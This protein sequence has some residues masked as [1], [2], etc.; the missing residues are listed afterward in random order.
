MLVIFL[1]EKLRLKLDTTETFNI[2]K[3]PSEMHGN[4]AFM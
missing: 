4:E 1:L 2:L 3:G